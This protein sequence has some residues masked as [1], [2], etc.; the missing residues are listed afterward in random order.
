MSNRNRII[1]FSV[2][3]LCACLA[4]PVLAQTAELDQ[5]FADLAE[6]GPEE[7]ARIAAQI[8]SEWSK[9]GSPAMDLL[10]RRGEDALDDGN[11]MVAVEH[12]TALIDHAPDFAEAYNGR[13]T[14]YY[15]T[16]K[17]GPALADIGTALQ[18]NPRHF[19]ALRGL[20]IIL[21]ELERPESALEIYRAVLEIYP[22]AE[23]VTEAI[24]RI[25]IT[26]EGR[27]L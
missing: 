20:A 2:A 19:G 21:E 18:L 3:A 17:Y 12:F 27:S 23:G 1:N 10:L 16:G 22:H 6:A 4:G 5:L 11:P 8:G 24:E 25:N 13:A 15:L 14:A 9:S 7:S 26:L